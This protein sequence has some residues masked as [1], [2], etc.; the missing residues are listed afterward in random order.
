MISRLEVCKNRFICE[1]VDVD[2]DTVC[3]YIGL[4]DCNGTKM[5]EHD[6]VECGTVHAVIS[7]CD[8]FASWR[9]DTNKWMYSHFFGEACEAKDVKVIGNIFDDAEL[10][11]GDGGKSCK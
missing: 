2:P 10:R 3:E 8:N 1:I 11:N 6:I 5:F 9:M 7:W 4:D